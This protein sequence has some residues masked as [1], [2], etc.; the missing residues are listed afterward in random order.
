[1]PTKNLI[2]SYRKEIDGLRALAVVL[3]I[4]FHAGITQI[5]SGFIGVDIFF[6]ISGFLITGIIVKQ[7]REEH[8]QPGELFRA[9]SLAYT[10]GFYHDV[11]GYAYSNVLFVSA[12]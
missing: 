1:M 10:A 8:L 4:L 6:A 12:G 9:S 7:K 2:D 5:A 11:P 3:V